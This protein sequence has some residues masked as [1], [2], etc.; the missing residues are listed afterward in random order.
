MARGGPQPTGQLAKFNVYPERGTSRLHYTVRIFSTV[1]TARRWCRLTGRV[2]AISAHG[3]GLCST[4]KKFAVVPGAHA[5]PQMGEIVLIKRWLGT[6]VICHES[7]H[8]AIGWLGRI[9]LL[10]ALGAQTDGRWVSPVE[11]RFAYGLGQ[12]SRQIAAQCWHRKLVE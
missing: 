4:W 3:K 7:T 8:A 11:E 9:G 1:A 2:G 10:R 12:I 5:S 6:E